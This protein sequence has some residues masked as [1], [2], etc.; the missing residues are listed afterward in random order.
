MYW[1][2]VSPACFFSHCWTCIKIGGENGILSS[3][4]LENWASCWNFKDML[5]DKFFDWTDHSCI[6]IHKLLVLDV[7]LHYVQRVPCAAILQIFLL[8]GMIWYCQIQLPAVSKQRDVRLY[9]FRW[10]IP[11]SIDYVCNLSIDRSISTPSCSYYIWN[12]YCQNHRSILPH[13]LLFSWLDTV[14]FNGLPCPNNKM[15]D[16]VVFDN[17]FRFKLTMFEVCILI[18]LSILFDTHIA[19]EIAI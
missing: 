5:L 15:Y 3:T 7:S 8:F 11:L 6:V 19:Y 18:W 17:R 14:E 12:R 13:F 2:R 9:G 10:S 16:D 4:I 1:H